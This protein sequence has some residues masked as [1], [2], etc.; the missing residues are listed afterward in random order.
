MKRTTLFTTALATAAT[1]FALGAAQAS[2]KSENGQN[3]N[4]HEHSVRDT[5]GKG[6]MV[7]QRQEDRKRVGDD[8][9]DASGDGN[10]YRER[11]EYRTQAGI[12]PV[13]SGFLGALQRD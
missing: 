9:A 13:I 5:S 10:K 3:R 2:D 4:A 1:L 11:K 6:D 12:P 7:R 8:K